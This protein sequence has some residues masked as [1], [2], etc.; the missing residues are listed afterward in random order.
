MQTAE[1]I[2]F[3]TKCFHLLFV[4]NF[5]DTHDDL[6]FYVRE[7]ASEPDFSD[8]SDDSP[9]FVLRHGS[10]KVASGAFNSLF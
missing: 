2:A 7:K 5:D 10:Q 6:V 8:A 9:Y 4:E 3:W 1:E